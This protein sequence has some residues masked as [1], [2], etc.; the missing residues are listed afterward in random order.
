MHTKTYNG[1]EIRFS[2]PDLHQDEI[3]SAMTYLHNQIEEINKYSDKSLFFQNPQ[4]I[5]GW[6]ALVRSIEKIE[7]WEAAEDKT[8]WEDRTETYV[9]YLLTLR[10]YFF[11]YED[12]YERYYEQLNKI[13]DCY[14]GCLER[15]FISADEMDALF[16]NHYCDDLENVDDII[17]HLTNLNNDS[18]KARSAVHAVL[19][20]ILGVLTAVMD[21]GEQKVID[22]NPSVEDFTKAIEDDLMEWTFSFGKGVFKEMKEDLNRYYKAHRT[23]NNTP[24]LWS[25][26]LDAD[27]N[28]LLMAKRQELANC[29]DA[30]QE[31]WGEDMKKQMDENGQLMQQIY[32]SCRTE[33][34]FDFGKVDNVYAFIAL[35]TPDNLSMFYDIIIRRTLIQCE[36]FPNLKAQHDEWLNNGNEQEESENELQNNISSACEIPAELMTEEAQPL[37]EKLRDAGF[38]VADGYA[39]AKSVSN[40]QAAYIADCMSE[41]LKIKYKWKVFEQL[42]NIENMAQLAGSWKQTG[43][44]P[45]RANEIEEITE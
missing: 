1:L 42:W 24:E 16:T 14:G 36:M 28:A 7:T 44:L 19:T 3:D 26:M 43:K 45:P 38:I 31:H 30:K 4:I 6:L 10:N 39:L 11:M 37:W 33:E 22:L 35:L 8:R 13:L 18:L 40:N 17:Q 15:E 25:E 9:A 20:D 23:D 21:R 32:S 29:D 27:E 41:K 12:L 5:K 34:L 2:G